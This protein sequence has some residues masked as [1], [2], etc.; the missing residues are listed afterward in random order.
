MVIVLKKSTLAGMIG[1]AVAAGLTITYFRSK[2]EAQQKKYEDIIERT[3]ETY[4]ADN[5]PYEKE[6]TSSRK[7]RTMKKKHLVY[8]NK[9]K[10]F[11]LPLPVR[12]TRKLPPLD[13]DQLIIKKTI[14]DVDWDGKRVLCRVDYNVPIRNGRVVD[15]TRILIT[16]DTIRYILGNRGQQGGCKC[17]I[18]LSHLGRPGK[19]Y[20][21]E[22]FSLKPVVQVLQRELPGINIRFLDNCVGEHVEQ[23]INNC[24][25]GTVFLLEN[26]R[27][28][29]EETKKG[30]TVDNV[31]IQASDTDIKKF[32]KK[33]SRLGDVYVFEAFAAA[34][35]NHSSVV[36]ISC[37]PRV[38]GKLMAKEL[39]VYASVLSR[40][41][42]PFLLIIGG[43]KVS[44]KLP[45]LFNMLDRVDSIIIGGAMAYTFKKVKDGM[46]IGNSIFDK[47]G[48]LQVGKF[49]TQAAQKGVKVHLP[50]DHVI[51]NSFSA[52][53]KVG[54]TDD[55]H[56]IPE[57]W[58]ALDVGPKTRRNW[59]QVIA[60]AN[61]ILWNG[62]LGVFEMGPF[63]TGTMTAMCDLVRATKTRNATSIIA[64]GNTA[65]ASRRFYYGK[66]TIASQVSHVSA[67]GGSSL[68]LMEGKVLL[69]AH[70]LSDLPNRKDSY[71]DNDSNSIL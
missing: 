70:F 41:K 24:E 69:G 38:A 25:T 4:F 59:S 39:K 37:K 11:P 58:M 3:N 8:Q 62:P 18:L 66:N 36:G 56:G 33:L 63:A 17:L 47:K 23:A 9:Q 2:F 29:I 35:R 53:A 14:H 52:K 45:V 49:M 21:R 12:D 34:H 32:Q 44:H 13:I 31:Q 71:F 26:L 27:F 61:T 54:I 20:K 22:D 55:E 57:G 46:Q 19:N 30:I 65:G 68:V 10:H 16:M 6:Q 42:K 50:C 48:A 5:Q 43:A 60:Q 28:H 64:G 1:C 67:G 7:Q 15:E 40:P 51:A